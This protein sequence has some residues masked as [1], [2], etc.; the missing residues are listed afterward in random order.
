MNRQNL[1]TSSAAI[2]SSGLLVGLTYLGYVSTRA[3][4]ESPKKAYD[5]GNEIGRIRN[6]IVSEKNI[7]ILKRKG[8]I[9]ID[10]VLTSSELAKARE[11]IDNLLLHTNS[12]ETNGHDD[13]D[14]RTDSVFWI[15]ETIGFE[16]TAL[17]GDGI[18]FALRK[19][20]SIPNELLGNGNADK[21]KDTHQ[22]DSNYGVPFLN[23]LACYDGKN[24]NYIA[25][26]DAPEKTSGGYSHPLKWLFQPGLQVILLEYS[27]I[28]TMQLKY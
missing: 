15:S 14:T 25:H 28:L 11:E 16:Q 3:M 1:R 5:H 24:A 19:V 21:I 4:R 6:K 22:D 10:N 27:C 2:L 23:Q 18:L 26:R 13:V 7:D 8:I 20:R 12:F 9:I 17:L